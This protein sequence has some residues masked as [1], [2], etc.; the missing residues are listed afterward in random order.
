MNEEIFLQNLVNLFVSQAKCDCVSD[1]KN[2]NR[3]KLENTRAPIVSG[4]AKVPAHFKKRDSTINIHSKSS[5]A[6]SIKE[7]SQC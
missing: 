1:P 5:D 4:E 3:L 2:P 6:S 7:K